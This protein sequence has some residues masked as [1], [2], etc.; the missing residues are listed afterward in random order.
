MKSRTDGKTKTGGG[1][2]IGLVFAMNLSQASK[3]DR[4]ATVLNLGRLLCMISE[5]PGTLFRKMGAKPECA[6]SVP[7]LDTQLFYW[8]IPDVFI[9]DEL[10]RHHV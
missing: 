6:L 10:D 7:Y 1:V 4:K 5:K 9:Q 8:F 3:F 2:S